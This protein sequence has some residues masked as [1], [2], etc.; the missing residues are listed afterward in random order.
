M[1]L[2]GL[3]VFGVAGFGALLVIAGTLT[4]GGLVAS[5]ILAG[6]AVQPIQTVAAA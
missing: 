3:V 5:I 1:L 6:R 2:S 4:I